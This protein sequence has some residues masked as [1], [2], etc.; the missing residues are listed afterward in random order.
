MAGTERTAAVG[1]PR[2][3][4]AI[5]ADEG[6]REPGPR[7]L[8]EH[9]PFRGG[10]PRR[11]EGR[12]RHPLGRGLLHLLRCAQHDARQH[13]SCGTDVLQP[14]V[15]DEPFDLGRPGMSGE[16][17]GRPL[18]LLAQQRRIARMDV[19]CERLPQ[20]AVAVVP[21]R[22]Q[23][24][25][26]GGVDGGPVPD[27]DARR[28]LEG[29]QERAIPIRV[30]LPGVVSRDRLRRDERVESGQEP[31]EVAVVRHDEDARLPRR[32]RRRCG[33]SEHPR[34]ARSVIGQL[35]DG[36]DRRAAALF[37]DRL[38]AVVQSDDG[39]GVLSPLGRRLRDRRVRGPRLLDAHLPFGDDQTQHVGR[40]PGGAIRDPSGQPVQAIRQHGDRGH[41]TL[42]LGEGPIRVVLHV[43]LH[44]EAVDHPAGRPQRHPHADSGNDIA[45]LRRQRVVEQA[46]ELRQRRLEEHPGDA[47]A[48][49]GDQHRGP[50]RARQRAAAPRPGPSAPR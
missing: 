15:R 37:E 50:V 30:G 14:P 27:H 26:D 40:R 6:R 34:P 21:H 35:R 5:R 16:E 22:D 36:L 45:Q 42:D 2:G 24:G 39:C 43:Q 47:P 28:V 11:E 46:V 19:G 32:E 48:L 29:P 4:P 49:R 7:D 25:D 33:G 1:A 9:G 18:G 10:V 41:D 8:D 20:Q 44:D 13:A 3:C 38:Q 17:E 23:A 31:I 12:R